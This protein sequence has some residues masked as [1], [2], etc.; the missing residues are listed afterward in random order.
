[1]KPEIH[2]HPECVSMAFMVFYSSQVI[3]TASMSITCPSASRK[4]T[5]ALFMKSTTFA[6][7]CPARVACSRSTHACSTIRFPIFALCPRLDALG[8]VDGRVSSAAGLRG[9]VAARD[10]ALET[11]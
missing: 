6:G 5:V 2:M 10:V 4:N 7:T 3:I 8:S 9:A 11:P 1:M